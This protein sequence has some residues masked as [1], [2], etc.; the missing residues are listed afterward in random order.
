MAHALEGLRAIAGDHNR[1]ALGLRLKSTAPVYTNFHL[2][3]GSRN[4]QRKWKGEPLGLAR[5]F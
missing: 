2:P 5:S 1:I 4:S 3:K